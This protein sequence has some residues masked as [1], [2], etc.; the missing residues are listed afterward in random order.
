MLGNILVFAKTAPQLF[1]PFYEDFFICTSDP[2]QTKALKLEILTTIATESSIP[3]IFEEFQVLVCKSNVHSIFDL[4][5]WPDNVL[6]DSQMK[7]HLKFILWL[8]VT[9]FIIYWGNIF[10]ENK[11]PLLCWILCITNSIFLN[12]F[13]TLLSTL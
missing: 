7:V 10:F 3:A 13:L 12:F 9:I 2:Y 5:Q 4:S 6:Y 1:A 8:L 11:L